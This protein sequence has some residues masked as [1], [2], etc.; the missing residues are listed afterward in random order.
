MLGSETVFSCWLFCLYTASGGSR[1][2]VIDKSFGMDLNQQRIFAYLMEISHRMSWRPSYALSQE[3]LHYKR[4]TCIVQYPDWNGT[5]SHQ[6]HVQLWALPL[7]ILP[8]IHWIFWVLQH[9]RE[10]GYMGNACSLS[11]WYLTLIIILHLHLC[12]LLP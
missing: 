3:A 2:H 4:H 8:N 9:I 1:Q 7:N 11:L 10:L 6:S 5:P 12:H